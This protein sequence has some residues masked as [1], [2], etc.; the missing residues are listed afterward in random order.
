MTATVYVLD[1]PF[2]AV[3]GEGGAFE[4]AGLPPGE[5]EVVFSHPFLGERTR[6]LAVGGGA[7]TADVTFEKVQ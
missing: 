5:H 3:T 4:V 7:V 6:K 2:F 1:H